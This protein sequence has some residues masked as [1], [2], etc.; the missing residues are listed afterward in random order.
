MIAA[1]K[2]TVKGLANKRIVVTRAREQSDEMVSL[3]TDFGAE[4]IP[5]PMIELVP[6]DSW[7]SCD[8]AIAKL[9][10]YDWIVFTSTNGVR[11]FLRR[12]RELNIYPTALL[13]NSV[14]AVGARTAE[15]LAKVGVQVALTPKESDA[16]GLV[17]TFKA[18]RVENNRILLVQ[19]QRSRNVLREGLKRLGASVDV[20]VAYKNRPVPQETLTRYRESLTGEQ[21][22]LLTFTSPSTVKNFVNMFGINS[23]RKWLAE[24]CRIAT[25]GRITASAVEHYE[26]PVHLVAPT[27]TIPAM[28]KGI[29][30]FFHE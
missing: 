24:G 3:L 7:H 18:F 4:V 15:L 21:I 28:I 26:L 22:D 9:R 10:D 29:V 13:T 1:P 16:E 12:L 19:P 30:D 6:P 5:M 25:L 17:E 2:M 8:T 14:A 23:I 27:A 11:F 20:A